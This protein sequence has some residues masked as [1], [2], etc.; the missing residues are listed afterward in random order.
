[1]AELYFLL[2]EHSLPPLDGEVPM[3]RKVFPL[4]Q[5]CFRQNLRLLDEVET[6]NLALA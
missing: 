2:E 6:L 3:N 4:L 5:I 1:M